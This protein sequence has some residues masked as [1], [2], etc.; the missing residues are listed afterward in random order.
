MPAE[1]R[2]RRPPARRRIRSAETPDHRPAPV[3]SIV[4]PTF[5]E[6]ENIEVLL[7]KLDAVLVGEQR[8]YIFVDDQSPDGTAAHARGLARAAQF[9]W[10]RAALDTMEAYARANAG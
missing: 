1:S 6:R 4:I 7:E 9:S 10:E 3:V 5:N 8:E 2:L